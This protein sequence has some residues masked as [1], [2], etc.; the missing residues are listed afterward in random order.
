[1]KKAITISMFIALLAI[2]YLNCRNASSKEK[3]YGL[4]ATD[5]SFTINF[6]PF[7]PKELD[8]G[9]SIQQLVEFAW[10]EF[11]ALN[12]KS[13]YDANHLRDYP[14]TTWS[15]YK[16]NTPFPSLNV[17]ETFA[18]RIEL[19][20]WSNVM[21]P[22]DTLPHYSLGVTPV[23]IGNASFNLFDNLDEN[24]EIGSCNMYA[25]VNQYSTQY[26]VFYQ[27]KVNR[28]EY[29]YIY[30]HYNDTSK[31]RKARDLT[32]SNI[33]QYA[34]YYKGA[35][36]TCD[37]PDSANVICLPCGGTVDNNN[38]NDTI[39]GAMEI[40]SAWRELTPSD[41]STKFFT[42]KVIYY[43]KGVGSDSNTV[44]YGNKTY[45]LIGLHI[46]HKTRN[47]PAFIFAT[48]EHVDVQK[49]SMG[50]I[51]L[52]NNGADSGTLM[53]PNRDPIASITEASTQY[54]HNKL[55][56]TSIWQN[57]RL[58]GVQAVPTNDTTSFSFFLANYVVESD[59]T[60][61]H[62]RG[63][64]IGTPHDGRANTLYKGQ[65]YSMGGCQGCH[66][67]AQ[68]SFG[69]DFSFMLDAFGKPVQ[70]PDISITDSTAKLK[71][72]IKAFSLAQQKFN[73]Q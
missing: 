15:Y 52:S 53:T 22:F 39:T 46:I 27:A 21:L 36:N 58:V 28:D 13:S 43:A 69:T 17:W 41:D 18:H 23:A 34:A 38:P 62:F 70:K 14:D 11:I 19:R 1:M 32:A 65:F 54:V 55:P 63:S 71:R 49:D 56:S 6:N 7:P 26:Q 10:E 3:N 48:F 9:A 59:Y 47:Y 35:T 2:L 29:N 44:Y 25:H 12:W 4:T 31:V 42:R 51:L 5:P 24:N 45:A 66:G 33:N 67:A 30:T 57:Y 60:L 68:K 73:K 61:N 8:S 50:Y 20:P 16:D 40:K 37:C 64:G 72:Y